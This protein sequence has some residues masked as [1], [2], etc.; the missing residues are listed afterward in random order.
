MRF[1]PH[2]FERLKNPINLCLV[3]VT[4][5]VV[6]GCSGESNPPRDLLLHPSDFPDQALNQSLQT[7]DDSLLDGPAVLVKLNGPVFNI[8][9]SLVLFES[10][11]LALNVL[12]EIKQDQ[13]TQGVF[14]NPEKGFDDHS[15]IMYETLNGEDG[16]TLF[17]VEG[18]ALVRIAVTGENHPDKI[19]EIARIARKKSAN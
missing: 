10:E 7:I 13:L 14:S 11:V 1:Q 2:S 16:S 3:L 6:T 12:A 8:L 15:G 5:L 18:R 9:E 17:F 4:L 19:W